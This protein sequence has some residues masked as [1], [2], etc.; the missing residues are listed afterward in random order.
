[1]LLEMA[2]LHI[3]NVPPELYERLRSDAERNGRSLNAEVIVQLSRVTGDWR[4][5][6]EW[7]DRHVARGERIRARLSPD[8][9]K[10]ED[11]IRADR[12]SR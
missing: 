11:L 5:N 1:M 8:S 12:D 9:P 3:R 4:G 7:W 2:T 6:Q 10:P